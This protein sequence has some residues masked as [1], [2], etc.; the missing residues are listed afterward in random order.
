MDGRLMKLLNIFVSALAH[1]YLSSLLIDIIIPAF[2]LNSSAIEAVIGAAIEQLNYTDGRVAYEEAIG[3][4]AT[5]VNINE[6]HPE[7]GNSVFLDYKMKDTHYLILP[8][9][10]TWVL[11][12]GI[13]NNTTINR[14]LDMRARLQPNYTYRVLL[15][16]N[17]HYIMNTSQAFAQNPASYRNLARIEQGI[18]VGNWHGSNV[19]ISWGS[20]SV[21]NSTALQPAALRAI[22]DLATL[23]VLNNSL[24][25]IVRGRYLAT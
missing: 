17:V 25:P 16:K 10:L 4:Y 22:A 12:N 1:L 15:D 14:F 7:Q 23:G 2:N 5:L 24:E 3:Y 13:I 20:Y 9:L 21:D 11:Y 8:Q 6:G 19:G 18:S